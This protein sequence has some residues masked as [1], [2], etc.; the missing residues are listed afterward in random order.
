M[1]IT[2]AP[3]PAVEYLYEV[4]TLNKNK[5]MEA[6]HTKINILSK[7]IHS[8]EVIKILQDEA[9]AISLLGGFAGRYIKHH[10]DK[11][12]IKSDI[13]WCDSETPHKMCITVPNKVDYYGVTRHNETLTEKDLLKIEQKL[14]NYYKNISTIVIA[15]YLPEQLD[16]AFYANLIKESKAHNIK[17]LLST[18]QKA[19]FENALLQKPYALMFTEEQLRSLGVDVTTIESILEVMKSYLHEGVHYIGLH[20]KDRGSF[21]ISKS[22]VCAVEAN[23]STHHEWTSASSGAFLGAFAIGINRKYEQEKIAKLTTATA[24]AAKHTEDMPLCT[25]RDIDLLVKKVKVRE[26]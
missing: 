25:K 13:V 12:K 14:K 15:G 8:A 6:T 2:V 10:M 11:V 9:M 21:L 4:D 23:I 22:K 19:V 16:S 20:L 18:G 5:D 7:G 1:I 24:R 17:V 3:C 26:L